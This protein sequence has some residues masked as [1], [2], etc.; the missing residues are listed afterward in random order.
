MLQ[1]RKEEFESFVR[2]GVEA[3]PP[4]FRHRIHN[5]AFLVESE[6]T[7][8]QLRGN[9][10]PKGDTLLGLYEGV[11]RPARGEEYGRLTFPDRITIFKKPIEEEARLLVDEHSGS[12]LRSQTHTE[13][14]NVFKGEV[15]RLVMNTVWHEVAHHF[16]LD[17]FAVE[18]RERERGVR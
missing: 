12:K 3:I 2:E 4:R 8:E 15:R 10:V 16:G 7:K 14:E 1:T 9:N 11:P 18:R 13:Q 17:E 6:P 5:V